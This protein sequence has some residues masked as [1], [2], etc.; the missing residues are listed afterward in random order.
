LQVTGASDFQ[1]EER[2]LCFPVQGEPVEKVLLG[3]KKLGFGV[4]KYAGFGGRVEEGE[5][6]EQAAVREL[7]EETGLLVSVDALEPVG[8]LT[9]QFPFRPR[10]NAIVHVFLTRTWKGEPT[11]T[12]EMRPVWFERSGI[13]L[14]KMWKDCPHWLPRILEG[15]FV[16]GNFA[17][18]D[19]NETVH[20][21]RVEPS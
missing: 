8:Q 17:F 14:D 4:G 15:D 13:P 11:E 1:P 21:A 19:D 2:T 6:I 5:T 12:T 18:K 3:L 16:R 7:K 10:W 20:W 9:L